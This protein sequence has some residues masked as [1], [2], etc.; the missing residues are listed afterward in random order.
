MILSDCSI[1]VVF[2]SSIACLC[3]SY[4]AYLLQHTCNVSVFH[5]NVCVGI[6]I[7]SYYSMLAMFTW[8]LV[9]GI[10][11]AVLVFCCISTTK[12]MD[13]RNMFVWLWYHVLYL[14][15]DTA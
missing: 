7:L 2:L 4:D 5:S 10:N 13:Q 6:M 15:V 3:R 12:K 9:E 11:I 1:L 14:L 8:M